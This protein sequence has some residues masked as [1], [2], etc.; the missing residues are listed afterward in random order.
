MTGGSLLA[1]SMPCSTVDT[2]SATVPGFFWTCLRI[3]YVR[4]ESRILKSI[5]SC[6]PASR[7]MEKCAQSI[8]QLYGGVTW[9]S[10]RCFHEP[11][12]IWQSFVERRLPNIP[13]S[14]RCL[15]RLWIQVRTS[16]PFG[17]FQI[18]LREGG[19]RILRVLLCTC[20]F[21]LGVLSLAVTVFVSLEEYTFRSYW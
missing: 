18:S 7:G 6:S 10:G 1:Q 3:F 5:S 21:A 11:P 12:C 8:L 13:Y 16:G 14:A 15:V 4:V 20:C 2:C 19:L 9:K 17:P